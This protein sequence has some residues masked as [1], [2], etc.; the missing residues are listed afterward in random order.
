MFVKWLFKYFSESKKI[1]YLRKKGIMLGSRVS[2]GRKVYIYMLQDF[3]VE[4]V[5]QQDNLQ[6]SPERLETF[7]SLDNLN[8]YLERE[9]RTAF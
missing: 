7:S 9:F 4:V 8:S 2:Q 1:I 6:L 5:Y 3:F